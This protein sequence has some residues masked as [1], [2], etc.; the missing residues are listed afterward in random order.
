MAHNF[1]VLWG[2]DAGLSEG[3][4]WVSLQQKFWDL[5]SREGMANFSFIPQ[6]QSLRGARKTQA[7]AMAVCT[8]SSGFPRGHCT[9]AL[10]LTNLKKI[11]RSS[12]NSIS[13]VMDDCWH[14]AVEAS[15]LFLSPSIS[16]CC[17]WRPPVKPLIWLLSVSI[18][19]CCCWRLPDKSFIW[20]L[21]PSIS[22]CCVWGLPVKS[23]MRFLSPSISLCSR[24]WLSVKLLIWR[25]SSSIS[26]FWELLFGGWRPASP[27]FNAPNP[28][29]T[30]SCSS[31][32]RTFWRSQKPTVIKKYRQQWRKK[33][34]RC[35]LVELEINGANSLWY[36]SYSKK[37]QRFFFFTLSDLLTY[38]SACLACPLSMLIRPPGLMLV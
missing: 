26:C 25:L 20:R 16:L 27:R 19:P 10:H 9:I 30:S 31:G 35:T 4:L 3:W 36:N 34:Q 14:K 32:R 6:I 23:S 12:S 24:W 21:S 13:L 28:L 22:V 7:A 1:V 8:W 15:T 2:A 5:K 29:V 33:K 17:C 37:L 18:S 38:H 11:L